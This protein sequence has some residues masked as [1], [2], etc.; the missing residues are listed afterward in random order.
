MKGRILNISYEPSLARTRQ[1]LL[2]NAGFTVTTVL[3]EEEAVAEAKRCE[4]D[5]AI[6]GHSIPRG[7]KERIVKEIAV[8]DSH[9]L[10]LRRHGDLPV[11]EADYSMEAIEG[12]TALL[13]TVREIFRELE[14]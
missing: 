10:S 4:Y 6:V 1:A 8:C 11:A 13:N 12:P 5:L 2:E 14:E 3:S 9:I 7:D